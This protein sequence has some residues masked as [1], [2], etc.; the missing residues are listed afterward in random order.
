MFSQ[1]L[2]YLQSAEPLPGSAKNT[3]KYSWS[4]AWLIFVFNLTP[5]SADTEVNN[6]T[7]LDVLK[8]MS[9]LK[10]GEPVGVLNVRVNHVLQLAEW[11]SHHVDVVNIQE[12]QLS[13]L[14]SI[15]TFITTSFHLKKTSG[16]QEKICLRSTL[17]RSAKSKAQ[18]ALECCTVTDYNLY[19]PC[20]QNFHKQYYDSFTHN[21]CCFFL[22]RIRQT[23]LAAALTL[24]LASKMKS[25]WDWAL[26]SMIACRYF[27]SSLL[28]FP[29]TPTIGWL[30]RVTVAWLSGWI[31]DNTYTQSTTEYYANQP[32]TQVSIIT[33]LKN[34]YSQVF[35]LLLGKPP[36]SS[37]LRLVCWQALPELMGTC[38]TARSDHLVLLSS[39]FH[40]EYPPK[41]K[42]THT[43]TKLHSLATLLG[44]TVQSNANNTAAVPWILLLQSYNFSAFVETVRKVRIILYV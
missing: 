8:P 23:L 26:A 16:D 10:I 18:L 2:L 31:Q 15:L 28:R 14:I 36:P 39:S 1:T 37:A 17:H 33:L 27:S 42:H 35:F 41:K 19:S 4:R 30:Q 22:I 11:L 5:L 44:P 13:I 6:Y 32:A 40:W 21:T 9:G 34:H 20:T 7:H 24:G 12:H 43:H 3:P 25:L 38:R 29:F